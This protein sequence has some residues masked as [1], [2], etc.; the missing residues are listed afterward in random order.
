[1]PRGFGEVQ[2]GSRQTPGVLPDKERSLEAHAGAPGGPCKTWGS[3]W[4]LLYSEDVERLQGSY[5]FL[6]PSLLNLQIP[7]PWEGIQSGSPLCPW[8]LQGGMGADLASRCD[9]AGTSPSRPGLGRPLMSSL[10]PPAPNRR[11]R[12]G[13]KALAGQHW[14]WPGWKIPHWLG[15]T[16]V[17][18]PGLG[19]PPGA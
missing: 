19:L 5:H 4:T 13:S 14:W 1:M 18:R 7:C 3:L 16:G 12:G 17:G 10:L 15:N 8:E 9:Q 6:L 11:A 2:P